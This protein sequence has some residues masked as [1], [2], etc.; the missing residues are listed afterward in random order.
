MIPLAEWTGKRRRKQLRAEQEKLPPDFQKDNPGFIRI[1][2]AYPLPD[3]M[4]PLKGRGA[5]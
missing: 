2:A 3:D 5:Y 4:F 1:P